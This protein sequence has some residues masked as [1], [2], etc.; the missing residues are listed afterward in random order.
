MVSERRQTDSFVHGHQK[1]FIGGYTHRKGRKETPRPPPTV[2]P[3]ARPSLQRVVTAGSF[4][5][6]RGRRLG[7]HV[8]EP[9]PPWEEGPVPP[10]RPLPG[11]AVRSGQPAQ[12]GP[13]P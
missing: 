4:L 6:T 7:P 9:S 12:G 3:N 8:P 10:L 5:R 1:C 2:D 13:W 11:P